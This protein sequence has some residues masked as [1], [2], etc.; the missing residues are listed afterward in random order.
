MFRLAVG[1]ALRI[2][3][4][5]PEI[6]SEATQARGQRWNQRTVSE[7][8]RDR[9]ATNLALESWSGQSCVAAVS[10]T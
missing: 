9:V 4:L 6:S 3:V 2:V 7:D 1:S 8:L 10:K 5:L